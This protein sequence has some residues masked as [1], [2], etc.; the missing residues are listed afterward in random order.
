MGYD[1]DRVKIHIPSP[2][3]GARPMSDNLA[4]Q[5][6]PRT[7]LINGV[8]ISMSPRPAFNHNRVA[9]RIAHLFEAHLDGRICTVIA[10][11]TDLYLTEKN[12][13]VPDMMVVCDRS[14]IQWDGVHGSPDLVVEVLS[15]STAQ[16]DR[17]YKKQVYEQCGV[18]EYWLV[19]PA[20][21]T[22]EQYF[23]QDSQFS[24][25]AVYH[26][27][28]PYMLP[29][30]TEEDKAELIPHFQCSLYDDFEISVEAIFQ[31]LL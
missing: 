17:L 25:H 27:Y 23:L 21:R 19:D 3:K 5:E 2:E 20:N 15:P 24:L 8:P 6:C 22:I 18:K 10:D 4:Y 30:L 7:E 31:G 26:S 9:F 16:N 12:H 1:K 11:G 28:P 13:F 14:K 29:S